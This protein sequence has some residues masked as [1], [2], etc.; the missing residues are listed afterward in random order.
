MIDIFQGFSSMILTLQTGTT[1]DGKAVYKDKAY[2]RVMP[3]A[4]LEDLYAIGEALASLSAWPLH[5]IE[6][7]NREDL[8]KT[9]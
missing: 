7:V 3:S 1:A 8:Y 9:V 2:S 6:R 5:H 4:P